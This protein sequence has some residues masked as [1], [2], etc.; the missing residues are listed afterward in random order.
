MI[1]KHCN[2]K[3]SS[4]KKV[5]IILNLLSTEPYAYK[6]TD[7]S[8]ITEINR[9]TVHRILTTLEEDGLAMKDEDTKKYKIGP[10]LYHMGSIYPY[11][12]NYENKLVEILTEMSSISKES[13]GLAVRDKERIISLYEIEIA[14][15]LKMNYRPGLFYPINRG[16]Y[17]KC[18]MAYYDQERVKQLLYAQKFEKVCKN[19][20]TDPEEILAEYKKIREQGYVISNEETFSHAMGIGIPI[21]NAKGNVTN[22]VA[23]SFF[24]QEHYQDTLENLKHLLF[25]YQ[26][27]ISKYI[28]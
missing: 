15:P 19:T 25:E 17:G 9:T 10:A 3:L 26:D 2:E 28:L 4:I 8:N 11:N 7:I 27:K 18:L 1:V 22:C 6:V 14:Q 23:I 12:F 21:F 16:C 20:L 5:I 24:K 13:V